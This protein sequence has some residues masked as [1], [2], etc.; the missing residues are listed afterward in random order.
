MRLFDVVVRVLDQQV[1]VLLVHHQIRGNAVGFENDDDAAVEGTRPAVG[2]DMGDR[3]GKIGER[4]LP[5]APRIGRI[6]LFEGAQTFV[7]VVAGVFLPDGQLL[8]GVVA[9]GADVDVDFGDFLAVLVGVYVDGE[10][11]AGVVLGIVEVDVEVA[12]GVDLVAQNVVF[13]SEGGVVA[14]EPAA[15]RGIVQLKVAVH[16]PGGEGP[17]VELEDGVCGLRNDAEDRAG[18]R[19]GGAVLGDVVQGV[20]D[21]L[22]Y[23]RRRGAFVFG[24]EDRAQTERFGGGQAVLPHV[25]GFGR[26]F[27]CGR[28]RFHVVVIVLFDAEGEQDAV[29][30]GFEVAAQVEDGGLLGHVHARSG[31]RRMRGEGV[32]GGIGDVFGGLSAECREVGVEFGRQ[33]GAV[34]GYPKIFGC[35]VR[36]FPPP[37]LSEQDAA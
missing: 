34:E 9:V 11:V 15:H 10:G 27:G 23:A 12:E 7:R 14:A 30:R 5:V 1:D 4:L 28:D 31:G 6:G 32:C 29:G 8:V 16:E 22:E 21:G 13:R 19:F 25:E 20:V 2:F 3:C 26:I 24:A 33:C 17:V 35:G 18:E 36:L 37:S